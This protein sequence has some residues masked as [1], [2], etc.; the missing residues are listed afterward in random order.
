MTDAFSS[1][2]RQPRPTASPY[3][4]ELDSWPPHTA[5][6]SRPQPQPRPQ[7][8]A[9]RPVVVG[10]RNDMR[11]LRD[12][13]RSQRR[14]ATLTALGCFTTFLILSAFVPSLMTGTVSGGLP[15]GLLLGL[16]QLPIICM[17]VG[18]FEYTARRRVDPVADRIRRQAELDAKRGASR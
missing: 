4:P 2:E 5:Y 1:P 15:A 9:P 13:Y 11:M 8:R 14:L 16:L 17:S 12:S 18:L 3:G 10:S 6:P 7:H